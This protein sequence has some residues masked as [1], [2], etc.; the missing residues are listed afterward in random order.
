MRALF[1]CCHVTFLNRSSKVANTLR[2]YEMLSL[3]YQKETGRLYGQAEEL[4]K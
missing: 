1:F 4:G 2:C 3:H